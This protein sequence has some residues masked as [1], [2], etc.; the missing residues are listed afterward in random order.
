MAKAAFI[1]YADR[2][3]STFFRASGNIYKDG[4]PLVP[5]EFM[6]AH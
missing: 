6:I 3:Y 5:F 1:F 4:T 2:K